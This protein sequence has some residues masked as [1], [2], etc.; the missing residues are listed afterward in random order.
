[1]RSG[2]RSGAPAGWAPDNPIVTLAILTATIAQLLDLGTFLRMV[3]VHGIGVEGNPIVG[4]LLSEYGL[5]FAVVAKVAV[6]ALVVAVAVFL[7][8]RPAR[9]A[10]RLAAL[11][12]G[13]AVIAGL[14]GGLS[15]AAVI[16]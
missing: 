9:V 6:L 12:A 8:E 4:H 16:L 14:I 10:G 11:V 15:N 2:L 5:Q 1:V 3:G 7:A 13:V